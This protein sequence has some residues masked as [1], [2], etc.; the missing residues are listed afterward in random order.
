MKPKK[1]A[2]VGFHLSGGGGARVMANLSNYFHKQNIEV[3]TII[4]H[5]EIGYEFSGILYNLGKLKSKAN[6]I[7]NKIKRFYHFRKYINQENFDYVIDFRFRKRIPQ[8]YLISRFVY[9]RKKT[10]YTIHSSKLD[11][12]LPSS[13]FW[14]NIIYGNCYKI[15]TIAKEMEA[16]IRNRYPS[17]TNIFTIYNPVNISA[18]QQKAKETIDLDFEYIIGAGTYN[19]NVKQF[20]KLIEAYSKSLLPQKGIQLLILGTGK[21][22]NHLKAVAKKNAAVDS[23]HFLGFQPNPYKFFSKAKYYV[24]TSKFEGMPMVLIE[25]LACNTPAVA[26]NCP[27]GPSE[28]IDNKKNGLLVEHQNVEALKE[29]FNLLENDKEL[30]RRCKE[31]SAKSINKFLADSV[32]KQWIDL[33]STNS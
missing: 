17:L 1:I 13:K 12:Y 25:S 26:F 16:I 28:I 11:V 14:T 19:T 20:D 5:D 2:L 15:I 29:A 3:H 8:E 27:T 23:V 6:T 33:M 32:G 31:S 10:I 21:L 7:F 22:L 9:N 18:I 30:Y 4:M 24:L